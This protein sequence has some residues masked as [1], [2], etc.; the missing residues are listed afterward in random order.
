MQNKQEQLTFWAAYIVCYDNIYDEHEVHRT[1]K[2]RGIWDMADIQISNKKNIQQ[3]KQMLVDWHAQ[4]KSYNNKISPNGIGTFI[5]CVLVAQTKG[6]QWTPK[7][8]KA[9]FHELRSYSKM[10]QRA[11]GKREAT[12][13]NVR[14]IRLRSGKIEGQQ[15]LNS[16][17]EFDDSAHEIV[18]H[19]YDLFAITMPI[20]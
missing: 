18:R 7:C 15:L 11:S 5:P 20:R 4:Q 3:A 1:R 8:F 19:T 16:S 14:P 12:N 9:I 6:R 2:R 17:T 10:H 13:K